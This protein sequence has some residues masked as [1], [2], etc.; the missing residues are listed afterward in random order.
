MNSGSTGATAPRSETATRDIHLSIVVPV[1]N[2]VENVLPLREE[3]RGVAESLGLE[4]EVIFVNDGSTDGTGEIL[5]RIAAS[6]PAVRVVRLR[7]NSG[8]TAAL[9]AGFRRA[10]GRLIAMMDGDR[11]N[12]PRDLPRLLEE[13]DGHDA[14]VGY[15]TGRADSWVRKLSSRIANSVRNVLSGDDII[16]TGCTLKVFRKE[17][18][19]A[20]PDFDGMHRFLPTLFR[21]AGYRVRQ[22]PVSHRPRVAGDSKYG[23]SNRLFRG[24][25]DL[26]AVRWMK[27]RRLR[28]LAYEQEDEE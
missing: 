7:E 26:M 20:I 14:A 22:V 18:L 8:Q 11:Q 15:R 27:R 1:Y 12:D 10:R 19:E 16:D 28:Y 5:K 6:D 3:I 21:I 24:L 4:H 17:C 25:G 13:L 9:L 23:I 2:E